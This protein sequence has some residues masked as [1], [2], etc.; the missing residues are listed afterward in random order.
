M[1][2]TVEDRRFARPLL[3]RASELGFGPNGFF[4]SISRRARA[5]TLF[6]LSMLDRSRDLTSLRS[7]LVSG[8]APRP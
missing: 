3:W 5:S 6:G 1:S 2:P 4:V 8:F 7:A